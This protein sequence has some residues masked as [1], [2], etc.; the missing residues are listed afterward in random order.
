MNEEQ[1]KQWLIDHNFYSERDL[2]ATESF[3]AEAT[4]E[5]KD[6]HID[7]VMALSKEMKK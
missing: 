3:L 1:A 6:E 4:I 2:G 5:V 7:I